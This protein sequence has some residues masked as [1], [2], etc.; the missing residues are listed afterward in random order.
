MPS[1]FGPWNETVRYSFLTSGPCLQTYAS[2]R[3]RINMSILYSAVLPGAQLLLIVYSAL[4]VITKEVDLQSRFD[5]GCYL[6]DL[7]YTSF[8]A[9]RICL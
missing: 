3:V 1:M 2:D 9:H 5:I 4:N 6:K 7:V 8:P